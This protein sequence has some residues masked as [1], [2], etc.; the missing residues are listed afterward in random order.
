MTSDF[1]VNIFLKFHSGAWG[2][3]NQFLKALREELIKKKIYER[4]P[5]KATC[6]LFNSHHNFKEL[7][8]ILYP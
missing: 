1:S 8:K 3:G 6:V 7:L 4:N 5:E 2:G